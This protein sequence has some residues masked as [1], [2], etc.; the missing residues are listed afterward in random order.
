MAQQMQNAQSSG[1]MGGLLNS[2]MG[3]LGMKPGSSTSN[4]VGNMFANSNLPGSSAITG[5]TNAPVTAAQQAADAAGKKDDGTDFDKDPNADGPLCDQNRD[6][7]LG[8][9]PLAQA[10]NQEIIHRFSAKNPVADITGANKAGTTGVV[11]GINGTF[12]AGVGKATGAYHATSEGTGFMLDDKAGVES[13]IEVAG[14]VN[15]ALNKVPQNKLDHCF[16]TVLASAGYAYPDLAQKLQQAIKLANDGK[17]DQAAEAA[18]QAVGG[19]KLGDDV[20]NAFKSLGGA[21]QDQGS[22]TQKAQQQGQPLQQLGQ[23]QQQGQPLQQLGQQQQQGQPLQQQGQQ[24][25]PVQAIIPPGMVAFTPPAGSSFPQ[26]PSNGV[27]YKDPSGGNITYVDPGANSLTVYSP[28][29]Q[30][31]STAQGF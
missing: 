21:V 29:G 22:T 4:P 9:R 18:K 12:D 30:V 6:D 16:T 7:P 1:G 8:S 31:L 26:V 5:S 14:M 28:T 15:A 20:A 23:Q 25:K 10:V 3:M 24:Q 27:A 19:G 17:Y 13:A 11:S 2:L